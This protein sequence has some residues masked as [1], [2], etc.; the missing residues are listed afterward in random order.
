MRGP[1]KPVM[2]AS[3]SLN[4]H[5]FALQQAPF[6]SQSAGETAH[7]S[8][9][10]QD[11]VAWHEDG[12]RVRTASAPDRARGEGLTHQPGDLPIGAGFTSGDL[13]QS[14]PDLPLKGRAF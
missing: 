5:A 10:G 7:T 11:S 4:L 14:G 8:V 1:D 6:P 9:R 3:R 13:E 12:N 2:N